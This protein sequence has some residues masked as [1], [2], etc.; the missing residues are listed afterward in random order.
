MFLLPATTFGQWNWRQHCPLRI[1]FEH[2]GF[3]S[4]W[5]LDVAMEVPNTIHYCRWWWW[6]WWWWW[7]ELTCIISNL[8]LQISEINGI[9][10]DAQLLFRQWC[11]FGTTMF[12][13]L[14]LCAYSLWTS[15]EPCFIRVIS[16][17]FM[18][19]KC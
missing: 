12:G 6:W 9:P 13:C 16:K 3:G 17:N 19:R 1:H 7:I 5:L 14:N 8:V 2:Q 11:W 15:W 4:R 18:G 10:A